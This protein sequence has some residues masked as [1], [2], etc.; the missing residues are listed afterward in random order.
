MLKN[1]YFFAGD[2]TVF[3]A[4]AFLGLG[5]LVLA[6]GA[7]AVFL[8]FD[9]L[10]ASLAA[11]GFAAATLD[12]LFFAGAGFFSTAAFLGDAGFLAG[13]V[14]FETVFFS[15]DCAFFG[16]D[17]LAGCGTFFALDVSL[18]PVESLKDPD[19]PLPFVWTTAPDVT[20]DFKY[21]LMNGAN[22]SPS[23]L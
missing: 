6:A 1:N 5:V 16:A 7:L 10:L 2:L 17:F 21:L 4:A 13:A 22:F 20:A 9:M 14:F 18:F 19:A 11:F 8:A 23:T 12:E 3:G 15:T